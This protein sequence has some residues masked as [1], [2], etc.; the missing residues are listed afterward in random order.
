[1]STKELLAKLKALGPEQRQAVESLIRLLAAPG[2][3]KPR[4]Q[5][6]LTDHPSFGAWASR[7]DLPA[8]SDE[9]AREWRKQAARRRPA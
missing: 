7:K 6:D 8:D 4:G 1:M 5:R 3:E 9:A 2:A